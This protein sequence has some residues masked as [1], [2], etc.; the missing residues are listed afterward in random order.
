MIC[1]GCGEEKKLIKAHIIPE[2]FF[3]GLNAFGQSAQLVWGGWEYTKRHPKGIYDKN[4]LCFDCEQNFQEVD[5]YAQQKLLA[6]DLRKLYNDG[7]TIAYVIPTVDYALIKL[8][9]ISVLWRASISNHQFYSKV[10]LGVY[11]DFAK[12]CIWEKNPGPPED[13][14]FLLSKFTDD[15][16]GVAMLNPHRH[17][18]FQVNYYSFYMYGFVVD[19]KVD[20]RNS[21]EILIPFVMQKN[22][23]LVVVARDFSKSKEFNI[24]KSIIKNHKQLL[25][26]PN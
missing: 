3:T 1:L 15:Q 6:S 4:I 5:H 9:F 10:N 14:S 19:I 25:Q 8:F 22:Q 26:Q 21:P 20:R 12:K 17:R 16:H 7:K 18:F 23:D 2:A 13:F 11:Q 24:I